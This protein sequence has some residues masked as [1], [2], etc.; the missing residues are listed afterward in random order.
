MRVDRR[1]SD[2]NTGKGRVQR[3]CL[4]VYEEHKRTD[5]LPTNGRFVFYELEQRGVVSKAHGYAGPRVNE[6]LMV[7]RELGLI[8]WSAI[9]DE[10]RTLV[11]PSFA[12]TVAEYVRDRVDTSRINM[13]G[14]GSPPLILCESRSLAGVLRSYAYAYL[15][16]IASTNGQVGGFLHTDIGPLLAKDP[17]RPVLYLGDLDLQGDQ[18]EANTHAVLEEIVGGSLDWGRVAI[19]AEQVGDTPPIRKKDNRT[20]RVHDAWETE[21]LGQARVVQIVRDA[22]DGLLPEAL[23]DV[24]A[25]E[26]EERETVANYLDEFEP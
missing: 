14:D 11:V 23:T 20:G 26:A 17:S 2:P 25:R 19:T 3:A 5:A 13:W 16:P 6:A 1:L 4:V 8:P 18:I 9:V 21:S 22:L 10:T 12:G 15:C 7:L 24:R